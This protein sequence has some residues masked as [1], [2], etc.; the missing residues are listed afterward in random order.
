MNK[1]TKFKTQTALKSIERAGWFCPFEGSWAAYKVN[2]ICCAKM[3]IKSKLTKCAFLKREPG[4][5]Q[6]W[7]SHDATFF[8][9]NW[10]EWLLSDV[11][12]WTLRIVKARYFP[13]S[14]VVKNLPANAGFNPWSRNVPHVPE[15][16][17]LQLLSL[18]SGACALQQWSHR[19]EDS[20]QPEI[21]VI[22]KSSHS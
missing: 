13:G 6:E 7:K 14:S 20:V 12:P 22:S 8:L 9:M 15:A 16:H 3:I 21:N 11:N 17:V 10:R 1:N 2:L 18:L 19:S 5:F 4:P